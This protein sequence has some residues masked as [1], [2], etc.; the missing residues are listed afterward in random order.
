DEVSE[1]LIANNP[2]FNPRTYLDQIPNDPQ[3]ID[4]LAAQRNDS[5]F[6]LG[7][8]YKDK[9]REN[10]LAEQRLRSL[11]GFTSEERLV[12]PASYYLYQIY[13]ADEN[14]TEAEK[15][16]QNLL[17]NHPDSRYAMAI[18]N[19][20]Q[21][22]TLENSAE[23][24]YKS[25]YSLFEEG[26]YQQVVELGKEYSNSFTDDELL[27]KIELLTAMAIGRMQGFDAYKEALN[28][29]AVNYP[30]TEEG[31]KA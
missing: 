15:Y 8:I 21:S 25:L 23:A 1:L 26:E 6:R 9:F 22:F 11:L 16:K 2:Q 14:I 19:P 24:S 17:Q 13:L 18:K 27:P 10:E 30:Q 12:V 20:G 29:V 3:I 7:L 4:S 31:V 5:Y 28:R